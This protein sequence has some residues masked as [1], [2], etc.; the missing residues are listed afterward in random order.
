[1]FAFSNDSSDL[2]TH[3]FY[4]KGRSSP[5]LLASCDLKYRIF[6]SQAGFIGVPMLLCSDVRVEEMR[7]Q[8]HYSVEVR[9]IEVIF[10]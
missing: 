2:K 4:R 9:A 1:M 8:R 10:E 3:G 6:N 7:A 5:L